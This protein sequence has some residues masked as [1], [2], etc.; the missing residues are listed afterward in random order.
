MTSPTSYTNV[1]RNVVVKLIRGGS[2]LSGKGSTCFQAGIVD[3][4]QIDS[5]GGSWRLA[6][7]IIATSC[8]AHDQPAPKNNIATYTCVDTKPPPPPPPLN[9][10]MYVYAHVM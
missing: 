4:C 5:Q 2:G 9:R 6:W 10:S 8:I 7:Y 1:K 3:P